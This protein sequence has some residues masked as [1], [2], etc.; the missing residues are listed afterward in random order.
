MA[1]ELTSPDF[2]DG[3]NIPAEYGCDGENVNP[4]L[5]ISGQSDEAESMVLIV[6][7]LDATKGD[8]VHWL[9]WNIEP[10]VSIIES[11]SVPEEAIEGYNDFGNMEYGGPCPP[12]GQKHRYQ[13]KLYE[14]DEVLELEEDATKDVIEKAMAGHILDETILTGVY[15]RS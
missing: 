11:G 5:E 14:L 15:E 12:K 9:V 7:D 3:Q 13:F 10:T 6:D 4:R 1:L 2:E 8:W